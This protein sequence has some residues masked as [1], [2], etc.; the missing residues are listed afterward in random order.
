[1]QQAHGFSGAHHFAGQAFDL[2]DSFSDNLVP[3][4]CFTVRRGGGLGGLLGVARD[5]LHGGGHLVHGGGD[6]VGLDFL[7]VDPGAGLL[8]HG[9]QLFGRAGDLGNAVADTTDQVAQGHAHAGNA[10]LQDTQLV[11]ARHPDVLGQVAAGDAI[12]HGQGFAQRTGDLP[13]DDDGGNN[14]HQQGQQGADQLQGTRLGAF[15]VTTVEL[16]LIQLLAQ[17]DDGRAL[18][19]HF[20]ARLHSLAV[21][22]FIGLQGAAVVAQ[23]G[24]QLAQGLGL[25][26]AEMH[27]ELLQ[28]GNCGVQ[29]RHGFLLGLGIGGGGVAT[30]FIAGQQERL[31]GGGDGLELLEALITRW[32]LLHATVQIVD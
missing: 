10:L 3:C 31:P 25:D 7:A 26:V 13:G 19:G 15:S 1:M 21:R 17:A 6:L 23:R 14:A 24:L 29:L 4:T 11:A 22:R 16:D 2:G 20:L 27:V 5:F 18:V 28:A 30:H 8:G 32:Q 12:D 9:R